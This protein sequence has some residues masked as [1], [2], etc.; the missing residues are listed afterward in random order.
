M[1]QLNNILNSQTSTAIN[2]NSQGP[3]APNKEYH[4]V[5]QLTRANETILASNYTTGTTHQHNVN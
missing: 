4:Q 5:Q 3:H 1:E 2:G